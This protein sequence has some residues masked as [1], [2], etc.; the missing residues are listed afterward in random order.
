MIRNLGVVLVILTFSTLI[1]ARSHGEEYVAIPSEFIL[2]TVASPPGCPV[3]FENGRLL[4]CKTDP[5]RLPTTSV[6]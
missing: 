4:M 3:Q 2:L 6:M 5:M 1:S